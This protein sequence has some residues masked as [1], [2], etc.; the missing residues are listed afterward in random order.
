LAYFF[1][2]NRPRILLSFRKIMGCERPYCL[3][4]LLIACACGTARRVIA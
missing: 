3:I 4:D 2:L 1:S